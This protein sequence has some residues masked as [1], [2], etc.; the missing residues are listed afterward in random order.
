MKRSKFLLGTKEGICPLCGGTQTLLVL[1]EGIMCCKDC[2]DILVKILEAA[3]KPI[4]R[5]ELTEGDSTTSSAEG[6]SK[7][8]REYSGDLRMKAENVKWIVELFREI[9]RRN[10]ADKLAAACLLAAE[11]GVK[12]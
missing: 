7:L 2:L 8:D 5:E 6:H 4:S 12:P 1:S 10:F 11:M 9:K 3:R